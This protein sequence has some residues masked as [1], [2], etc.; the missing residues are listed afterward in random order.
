ML[1]FLITIR[2][3]ILF[4]ATSGLDDV[5][6]TD[7]AAIFDEAVDGKYVCGRRFNLVGDEIFRVVSIDETYIRI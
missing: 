7:E 4:S 3:C 6:D 5:T 2:Y 1:A